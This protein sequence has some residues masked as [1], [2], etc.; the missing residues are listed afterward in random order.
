LRLTKLTEEQT[1]K[2]RQLNKE[3]KEELDYYK[4]LQPYLIL[5]SEDQAPGGGFF[6]DNKYDEIQK[7]GDAWEDLQQRMEAA[8]GGISSTIHGVG[9]L[10]VDMFG[11]LTE[12]VGSAIEAWAL[13]G[14]SIGAALKKALAAELAHIAGIATVKALEATAL[15]FLEL[16]YGDYSGAANAF[17]SAGLWAAL[18]AGT[19]LG[20]RA[21]SGGKS[22]G[23]S[24]STSTATTK[25][26]DQNPPPYSRQTSDTFTSGVVF[27]EHNRELI[28]TLQKLNTK[29]DTAKP[30]DVF[31][32]G[33][34]QNSGAVSRELLS[35]MNG[36]AAIGKG[37]AQKSGLVR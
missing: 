32:A 1:T 23:A 29:L 30:G 6:S 18:A 5:P 10:A 21:I 31:M 28:A 9:T 20:A 7:F 13:Y 35:D 2:L 37:I 16:A 34:K 11:S 14:E 3:R 33:M 8:G 17:V 24:G 12:A 22:K 26:I 27:G 19:A 15:G 25:T 36:N 4:N